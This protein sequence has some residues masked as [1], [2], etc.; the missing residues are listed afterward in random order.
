MAEQ[1]SAIRIPD[2]AVRA[3]YPVALAAI[4]AAKAPAA[5]G[6]AP[7]PSSPGR[8]A[9][10]AP[11]AGAPAKQRFERSDI[12]AALRGPGDD[13]LLPPARHGVLHALRRAMAVGLVVGEM[14]A[15]PLGFLD[16]G[17]RNAKGLL[18][19]AEGERFQAVVRAKALVTASVAAGHLAKALG[20]RPPAEDGEAGPVALAG[21]HEAIGWLVGLVADG[22]RGVPDDASALAAA[23]RACFDAMARCRQDAARLPDG[24]L[25]GFL[26]ASYALEEDGF[27]VRGF[28][29]PSM[30]GVKAAVEIATKRPEEVIGNHLA[31]A[32][33]M[34]LARQ[35][36]CHDFEAGRNP[37]VEVGGFT[38]TAIGDG[39]PGTGK[40][41]L[42]QMAVGLV[43]GYADAFGY[44]FRYENFGVDQISEYQGK[45]GQNCRGFIDRVL[46]RDAL[47]FGTI[48][49]VDQVAGRRD[50]KRASSGQQEVTAVLM[51][52]FAGAG[53]VVR[54]NAAFAMF[55]N[56]PENVDDALRQ[57]AGARWLIDGPQS[58]EDYV[59]ILALLLGRSQVPLGDHELYAAQALRR[60]VDQGY[61][62]NDLPQEEGL[63]AVWDAWVAAHGA[64]KDVASLG[65]YLHAI[66]EREPRFTGRA[67]KN[68]AD[69]V[70]NRS[71]DVDLPDAWFEGPDAFARKPYPEK[72][73]MLS[74]LRKPVDAAMVIQEINRYA[75]SEFRYADRSDEVEIARLVREARL[76]EAAR[77]RLR[78]GGSS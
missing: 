16:L 18:T 2:A 1:S 72:V 63:R 78:A 10:V 74:A 70:K 17:E 42:I 46:G 24:L 20:L 76:M 53:T 57:R 26:R 65:G 62:R 25:D 9:Y 64:P 66:K 75:D 34:R 77:G 27:R 43:K 30:T 45:S 3:K 13:P 4:E 40:T 14:V 67:V 32:Q 52:A 21:A 49:D 29:P 23:S 8:M 55:S 37:F 69:A 12:A 11:V 41:T 71:M 31:K 7:A 54:G 6:A 33:A 61:R 5:A 59:D 15:E 19:A 44:A 28:E 58:R 51:D 47:G 38:F 22:V 36:A 48:D 35:L 50:D 56:H 73:A 68:I 60:M 39:R